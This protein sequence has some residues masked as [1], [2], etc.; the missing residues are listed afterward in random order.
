MCSS[1]LR[2]IFWSN[3]SIKDRLAQLRAKGSPIWEYPKDVPHEY[4]KQI[5]SEIKR[6]MVDKTTKQITHRY[7]KLH[8]DNHMWD[9]EAMTTAAALMVGLL[10]EH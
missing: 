10:K 9:T 5:N 7:V 1:D 6:E 2:Y 8:R 4:L 3:E